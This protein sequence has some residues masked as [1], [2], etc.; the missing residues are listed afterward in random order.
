MKRTFISVIALVLLLILFSSWGY[1]GHRIISENSS[2]SFNAEML[3][4]HSWVAFITDH[5]SD[6]DYRKGDDPTEAYKHYID[7]D[8]FPDFETYGTIEQDYATAINSYGESLLKDTG[9]LPWATEATFDSL[10]D[11]LARM[12]INKAK[13]FAADLGHY[14]ADG[15]MPLHITKNYNG[16]LSGNYGIHYRYESTMINQFYH[17]IS[18][19][20]ETISEIQDVNQYIF[21]YI[22]LNYTYKDSVLASDN[23]AKSVNTNYGSQA[24]K[25]ALWNH[26]K[27]YTILLFK[28]AS[29]ALAELIYTAWI[30]AGK[31]DISSYSVPFASNL[32]ISEPIPNP[33]NHSCHIKLENV[34]AQLISVQLYNMKGNRVYSSAD[35]PT[36]NTHTITINKNK[37]Q[38]GTY[39]IK[40]LVENKTYSKKIIFI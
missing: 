17:Q 37:L 12:D 39:F 7:I 4:F 9:I 25:T 21:D 10:R 38:A 40:I 5:A 33:T 19:S 24:Y 31:P 16:Q 28:N 26:S 15:H 2:K 1:R 34:K 29:K 20:G 35:T 13:I 6:A 11:C 36:S 30:Q 27:N 23:Y 3:D 14:V 32:K 18:Y 8:M 22:Y